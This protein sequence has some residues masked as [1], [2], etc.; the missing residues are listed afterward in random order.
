M[1]I[2]IFGVTANPVHLGHWEAIKSAASKVDEVWVSP[3]FSHPFGKKFINYPL[4]KEMLKLMLEEFP[5]ENVKLVELDKEYSEKYNEM[6]YSYNLLTYLKEQYP[7]H[8]FKLIIG[9]DN[10]KPE[11]WHKFYHYEQIES[12]FGVVV[13]PDRGVHSTQIREMLNND[14]NVDTLVGKKVESLI[15]QHKLYKEE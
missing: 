6:V 10:Y 11:V 2:G 14:E 13:V 7:Q 5:L 3:V 12:E 1:Q 4:R 15:L 8:N 9:E